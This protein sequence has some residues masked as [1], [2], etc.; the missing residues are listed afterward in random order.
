MLNELAKG[1]KTL[2]PIASRCGVFAKTDVQSLLNEGVSKAD[3]AVS[4]FQVIVHQ[5]ISGL[6]CGRKISPENSHLFAAMGDAI[7]L[8]LRPRGKF[9][10]SCT[11]SF[12]RARR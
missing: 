1:H 11:L 9:W 2:Y 4:I 3:V 12:R 5:T 6:A 8:P 7:L 10:R